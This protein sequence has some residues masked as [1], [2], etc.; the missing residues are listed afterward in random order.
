V[1]RRH[2]ILL[3]ALAAVLCVC[4]PVAA[5]GTRVSWLIQ[6]RTEPDGSQKAHA[7]FAAQPSDL[8]VWARRM[9]PTHQ[10]RVKHVDFAKTVLVAGFLD[11]SAC[12]FDLK[13]KGY[14]FSRGRL[15]VDF[16]FRQSPIGVATCV[17]TSTS[18]VVV[19][20]SRAQLG[21]LP[22]FVELRAVAHS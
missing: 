11:G 8:G 18:Y 12:I 16:T 5:A 3:A 22:T 1:G 9:T 15:I 21:R 4:V 10:A 20:F 19:A 17:K 6:G 2:L 7:Y 14:T 13:L